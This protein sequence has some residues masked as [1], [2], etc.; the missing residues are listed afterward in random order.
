MDLA[1]IAFFAY[2]RSDH[3]LKSLT[4]LAECELAGQSHLHIFCDG[5]KS[6]AE[7]EKVLKVREIVSS[8][9]WCDKV[10]IIARE[11]NMGLANSIISETSKLCEQYGR[12]I[13]IEDDLILAPYFLDYMNR[14]LDKYQHAEQ[15]MQISGYMFPVTLTA[16]T[17]AIFLPFTTTWGWATW[18]RAWRHFDPEMAGYEALKKD[19]TVRHKFNLYGAYPYFDMLEQQ[20]AGKIDSWGIRWYLTTFLLGGLT[21]HPVKSLVQNIGFDASGTHTG[22]TS[23]YDCLFF[24]EDKI[25]RFP[26]PQ[27]DIASFNKLIEYMQGQLPS[28]SKQTRALLKKLKFWSS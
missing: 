22:A 3:T 17:E 24:S 7:V 21:L 1:P 2:N 25:N 16:D 4:S 28:K 14:A 26:E 27:V 10:D 8:K 13:V 18:Q 5:P 11:K 19:K 15:V 6:F 12:V 20:L 9:K 23:V